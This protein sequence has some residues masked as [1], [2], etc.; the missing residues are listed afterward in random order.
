[1]ESKYVICST[2]IQEGVWLRRFIAELGIVAC[3][4]KHVI[5]RFDMQDCKPGDTPV[6]KRD[7][8]SLSQCSKNDFK[9]KEM[10]K[11]PFALVV[12][13]HMYAQVCTHVDIA[14]SVGMLGRYLNNLGMDHCK[15]TK[16]I[17]RYLQ[18]TKD[19]MLMY[20]RSD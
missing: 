2:A 14:Y 6:A 18:R 17:M 16:R 8:F 10:Q 9:V 7:K 1:M 13:S 20:R 12:G 4:S 11:I 3:A 5:K 19:Y 15:A